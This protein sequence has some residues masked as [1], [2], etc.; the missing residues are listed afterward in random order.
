MASVSREWRSGATPTR[1]CIRKVMKYVVMR[2]VSRNVVCI[3]IEIIVYISSI[4]SIAQR[5]FSELILN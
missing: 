5:E 1:R 3:S 4:N 2:R